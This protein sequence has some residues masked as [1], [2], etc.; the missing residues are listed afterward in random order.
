L[1]ELILRNLKESLKN[2]EGILKN[3]KEFKGIKRKFEQI[4]EF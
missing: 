1:K 4:E 3:F 2:E